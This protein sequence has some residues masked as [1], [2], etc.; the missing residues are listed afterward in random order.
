MTTICLLLSPCW[1]E[2][3]PVHTWCPQHSSQWALCRMTHITTVAKQKGGL[4]REHKGMGPSQCWH[5]AQQQ[6]QWSTF[7]KVTVLKINIHLSMLHLGLSVKISLL[8]MNIYSYCFI[9]LAVQ[10]NF[11]CSSNSQNWY[12]SSKFKPRLLS[13]IFILTIPWNSKSCSPLLHSSISK[14][15]LISLLS[16]TLFSGEKKIQSSLGIERKEV[17]IQLSSNQALLH[18]GG[19]TC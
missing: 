1:A 7:L 8:C 5:H 15:F 17:Q 11:S 13:D 6:L 14:C 18:R 9:C 4:E 16:Q 12:P 2:H 10:V 19:S 3:S